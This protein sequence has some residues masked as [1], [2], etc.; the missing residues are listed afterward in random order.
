[1]LDWF[2]LWL[3][4]NPIDSSFSSARHHAVF[5]VVTLT[6][7]WGVGRPVD[8]K[9]VAVLNS[10]VFGPMVCGDANQD[11]SG[12][13]ELYSVRTPV[14][15]TLVAFEHRGD[16]LYERLNTP[17]IAGYHVWAFG[18]GDS[19]SLMELFVDGADSAGWWVLGVLECPVRESLP[20]RRVWSYPPDG[21][22][23]YMKYADMDRDGRREL[24]F[25]FSAFGTSFFENCGDNQYQL[26]ASVHDNGDFCI[27]DFDRDSLMELIVAT[28]R[29]SHGLVK[30]YEATGNDNEY[31]LRW[32]DTTV[33]RPN[34]FTCALG[35]LDLDGW[36]EFAILGVEGGIGK[37]MVYEASGENQYQCVWGEYVG[38]T[39]ENPIA[40]GDVDGDGVNEFGIL[41]GS[42]VLYKCTGPNTYSRIWEVSADSGFA[43]MNVFDLNGNGRAEVI[44]GKDDH[45][46]LFEDC[47]PGIAE[48]APH[49][50]AAPTKTA[51]IVSSPFHFEP[52]EPQ[53]AIEV[54]SV[55]GKLVAR[56]QTE[57]STSWTWDLRDESGGQV[58]AG[59][60]LAVIRSAKRTQQLK[61]CVVR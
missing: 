2:E 8:M 28:Y 27:G 35:D 10:G 57:R 53:S 4:M 31:V 52:L 44:L 56:Q 18:D 40:A 54:Y 48:F 21:N 16:N 3:N 36:P 59:T 25:Y 7:L 14:S 6:I 34:C 42:F 23:K 43:T 45:V 51:T 30:L 1:M 55:D 61:L 38:F 17:V 5:V 60:Y 50:K 20:T 9:R 26:V 39:D 33:T 29:M 46:S 19:D 15:D 37:L 24:I 12:H 41:G 22:Y 13:N 32:V 11:G 47:S 58:P 49:P